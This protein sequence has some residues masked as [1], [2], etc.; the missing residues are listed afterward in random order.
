MMARNSSPPKQS[1]MKGAYTYT[2]PGVHAIR[3]KGRL[4]EVLRHPFGPDRYTPTG[5]AAGDAIRALPENW[6]QVDYVV[7][8]N[9]SSLPKDE[10]P[11]ATL[12]AESAAYGLYKLGHGR[13]R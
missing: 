13:T 9:V 7:T 8:C 5:S 3:I 4:A 6:R 1:P 2:G 11:N 10:F 12:I